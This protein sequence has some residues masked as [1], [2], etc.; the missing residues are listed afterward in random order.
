MP[1]PLTEVT[2]LATAL[3]M[4]TDDL[5]AALERR[6]PELR[7]VGDDTWARMVDARR[8]GVHAD[9]FDRAFAN[10]RAFLCAD[11]AL[12]GRPPRLVEW[13]G[14]HRPPGDDII[15]A[16]LRVDHAYLVSCKYLSKVMLNPGPSRLFERLLVGEERSSD[17]WFDRVAPV[18]YRRFYDAARAH[19]DLGAL[20][21]DPS[22]LTRED[23]RRLRG[24]LGD[25]FLPE[26][27]REPWFEL[28]WATASGSAQRWSAALA[29]DRQRL[30][31]LWR[32][33]RISTAAYYVLGADRSSSLRC[34]VDS[35]WDWLDA[36]ELRAFTADPSTAGQPEVRW[37]A[38]V[39]RRHDGSDVR[40]EGHV[41]IRWSH[42]RFVGAPEAKVYLDTPLLEVP[43]YHALG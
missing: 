10:G 13:K 7:G 42:G 30:R 32:L 28:C 31:L 5:D 41:E 3:G 6:P 16:D 33:L 36:F 11:D 24:A 2:E 26:E 20:P 29:N 21:D 17:H 37:R 40:V 39:R 8:D 35:N 1:G 25:R 15:P 22:A 18:E 12:R 4:L 23:Q 27:L 9:A 19:A 43:G 14:P 34:R 38:D